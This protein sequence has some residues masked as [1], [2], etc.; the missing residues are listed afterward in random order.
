MKTRIRTLDYV[1][2]TYI[3]NLDPT[4]ILPTKKSANIRTPLGYFKCVCLDEVW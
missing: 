1:L 2:K 3:K 4:Q